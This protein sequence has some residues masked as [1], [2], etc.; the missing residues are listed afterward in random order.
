MGAALTC[1]LCVDAR[2]KVRL[3]AEIENIKG[4]LA[5]AKKDA[6]DKES[7]VKDIEKALTPQPENRTRAAADGTAD[8]NDVV[9]SLE[10]AFDDAALPPP[11]VA[12]IK[13][14]AHDTFDEL[15]AASNGDDPIQNKIGRIVRNKTEVEKNG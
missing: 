5:K 11:V 6:E 13:L 3:E 4:E 7:K 15:K 12:P 14:A 10:N 9:V 2:E 8:A 1:G